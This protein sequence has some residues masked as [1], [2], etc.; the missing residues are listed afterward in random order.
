[1][2]QK[3]WRE[4]MKVQFS[5]LVTQWGSTEMVSEETPF[6]C[7]ALQTPPASQ[8]EMGTGQRAEGVGNTQ[9]GICTAVGMSLAAEN[10]HSRQVGA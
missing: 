8:P 4:V 9:L 2:Q 7:I 10:R 3:G 5:H 1:M 6:V